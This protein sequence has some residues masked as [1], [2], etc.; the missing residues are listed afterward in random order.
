MFL[1]QC[2]H[3]KYTVNRM[4][5]GR[6]LSSQ[7][8]KITHYVILALSVLLIISCTGVWSHCV[9]LAWYG[10]TVCTWPGVNTLCALGLVWPHCAHLAWCGHT[11]CATHPLSLSCHLSIVIVQS[12]CLS[13][14]MT[15]NFKLM[16]YLFLEFFIYFL[17]TIGIR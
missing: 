3:N 7:C 11:V 4:L 17:T 8:L 12:L 14:R 9:H 10:H 15:Y 16:I 1:T 6:N 13:K 5:D 2:T